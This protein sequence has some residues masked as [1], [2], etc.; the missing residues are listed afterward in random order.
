MSEN[1]H[2][3]SIATSLSEIDRQ[4]WDACANPDD[5]VFNPFIA[6]DFLEALERSGSATAQ[7]GWHGQHMVLKQSEG[8]K[9]RGVL[10]C[11]LKSH[12][13]GEYVFDYGWADA[14]ER[15]GG[16]YYPKLQIS[17]PFTPVTG[18]RILTRPGGDAAEVRAILASAAAE[19]ARSINASS[20]HA[21]FVTHNEWQELGE[22]GYLQRTDQQFHFE[23]QDYG[24]FDGFLAA[25]SS[26]KRKQL[27]KERRAA[28]SHDIKIEHITGRDITEGHLDCFFNFYMDTGARKWGSPY[29][30]RAFFSMLVERMAKHVLFIFARREGRII[31]GAMNMIGGDALYGRYWGC[32]EDHPF[33]HFEV[34]Y[35]QAI[36][37]ALA[38]GLKRV[39][40]GAQGGHKLVRGYLPI[41]TYS[42]HWIANPGFRDAVEHF[43]HQER[44]QVEFEKEMLA[45]RAPFKKNSDSV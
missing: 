8:D 19:R 13:Q 39:E 2:I 3:V 38:N 15:A 43:L 45:E 28:L 24:D 33:L 36:D 42:A 26:R 22:L 21:T 34:C 4:E 14:F 41:L 32:I 27:K 6:Y 20:I 35:Y 40:A 29:L 12:S 9:F 25:L 10:P 30:T 1:T 7:T 23:D 11:Y 31:A 16:R 5:T 17:V 37:Y 44:Q 18:P